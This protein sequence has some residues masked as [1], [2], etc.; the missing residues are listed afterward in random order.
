M[1]K[2]KRL[3]TRRQKEK[4]PNLKR[5][6]N[7]KS[8]RDYVT[9]HIYKD[10]VKSVTGEGYGLRPLNENELKWLDKFEGEYTNAS[11]ARQSDKKAIKKQFHNTVELTK[12]CTDRNNQR[13]RCLL[14][15][16]KST[17]NIEFR[18]WEEFDE[19]TISEELRYSD[20]DPNDSGDK[21]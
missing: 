2:S 10:G 15:R 12:D 18:S 14:N 9:H 5:S 21:S 11:V 8:R 19:S 20:Y 4:Y 6:L 3:K 7:L 13:N 1:K 16:A 17:N